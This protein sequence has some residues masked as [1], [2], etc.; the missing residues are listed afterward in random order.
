MLNHAFC[1]FGG[2]VN[3]KTKLSSC[4]LTCS[5]LFRYEVSLVLQSPDFFFFFVCAFFK[6]NV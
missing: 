3:L 2:E 5:Y 1:F 4:F 6:K